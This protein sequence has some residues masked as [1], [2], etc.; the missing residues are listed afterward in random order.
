MGKKLKGSKIM[1]AADAPQRYLFGKAAEAA[2]VKQGKD[3]EETA[4]N[5]V[6]K[7][8]DKLG[9]P[10]STATNVAKSLGVAA[11]STFADPTNLIPGAGPAKKFFKLGSKG[12]KAAKK[13]NAIL[14]TGKSIPIGKGVEITKA[15][16]KA[17]LPKGALTKAAPAV[18]RAEKTAELGQTLSQKPANIAKLILE[19][20]KIALK[21]RG[22]RLLRS[23]DIAEKVKSMKPED[24]A[25][26]I[27]GLNRMRN[28]M[29]QD[30]KG[31]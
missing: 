3:S 17:S 10:D 15:A 11:L 7:A 16:N 23:P 24:R 5:L 26:F 30:N 20:D 21:Q 27:K 25:K 8:A 29:K 4:H 18:V 6:Q 14:K 19:N 9:L 28:S 22:E 31:E 2:G 12:A 1:E 13:A